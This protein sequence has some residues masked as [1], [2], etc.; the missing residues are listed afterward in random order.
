MA[1]ATLYLNRVNRSGI[2]KGGVIGGKKQNGNYKM[3]CRFN[4]ED[5]IFKIKSINEKRDY[6]QVYNLHAIDFLETVK[7]NIKGKALFYLD[8]P[9]YNQGSNLYTNFFK[10]KDHEILCNYVKNLNDYNW[11]VTYDNVPE[12]MDLYKNFKPKEYDISYSTE[13]KR[14]GKELLISNMNIDFN[15]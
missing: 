9:Y 13:R 8:P 10:S 6:I 2:L 3:D 5:L 1:V 11:I 7:K 4:K 15:K 12:I 14:I